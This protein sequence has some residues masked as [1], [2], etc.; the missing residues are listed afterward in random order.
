MQAAV[1]VFFLLMKAIPEWTNAFFFW[2][3]ATCIIFKTCMHQHLKIVLVLQILM[4]MTLYINGSFHWIYYIATINLGEGIGWLNLLVTRGHEKDACLI[5]LLFKT[6]TLFIQQNTSWSLGN[7]PYNL[8]PC[9]LFWPQCIHYNI[10][11]TDYNLLFE[12][13]TNIFVMN[14]IHQKQK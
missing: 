8:N 2:C 7:Y 13:D 12:I 14:V 4:T 6:N 5:Y 10:R 3:K 11:E 9:I 1:C